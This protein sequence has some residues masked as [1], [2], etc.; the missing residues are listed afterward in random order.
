MTD[1]TYVAAP[2]RH[3]IRPELRIGGRVVAI[4]LTALGGDALQIPAG[5]DRLQRVLRQ[6]VRFS[7]FLDR[8]PNVLAKCSAESLLGIHHR[9]VLLKLG[10]ASVVY[11]SGASLPR[12]PRSHC[13]DHRFDV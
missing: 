3:A 9:A 4:V 2:R 6:I 12:L 7:P 1:V 13:F 10:E 8:R 5:T 11:H